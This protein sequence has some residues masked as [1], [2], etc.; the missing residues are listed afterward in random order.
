M[1]LDYDNAFKLRAELVRYLDTAETIRQHNLTLDMSSWVDRFEGGRE[2]DWCGTVCCMAGWRATLD[3]DDEMHKR[4]VAAKKASR[5]EFARLRAGDFVNMQEYHDAIKSLLVDG[6]WSDVEAY[7]DWSAEEWSDTVQRLYS[8][9]AEP[10][11][12]MG[13]ML[14][15][16]EENEET[17]AE[18]LAKVTRRANALLF[19]VERLIEYHEHMGPGVPKALRR[20]HSEVQPA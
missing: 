3:M 15:G 12:K 8:A 14:F 17:E 13:N 16:G 18:T 2:A 9:Q 4:L 19:R 10:A 11:M 5:Q 7:L 1:N 6:E 20:D